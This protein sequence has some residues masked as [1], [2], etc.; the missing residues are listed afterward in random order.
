MDPRHLEKQYIY[1]LPYATQD[2][3]MSLE[4]PFPRDQ[5]IGYPDQSRLTLSFNTLWK[6]CAIGIKIP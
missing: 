6:A 5:R 2:V 1:N 4:D 3:H